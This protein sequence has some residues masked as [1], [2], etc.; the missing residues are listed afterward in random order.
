MRN[1]YLFSMIGTTAL[2]NHSRHLYPLMVMF[3]IIIFI[4]STTISANESRF[5]GSGEVI[6]WS[7]DQNINGIFEVAPEDVLIILPGVLI[8]FETPASGLLINGTIQAAGDA[9]NPIVFD[10]AGGN[11]WQGIDL[12]DACP[13]TFEYCSFQNIDRNQNKFG[14]RSNGGINISG[15]DSVSF[16]FSSF[17]GNNDGFT[18]IGSNQISFIECTF[19]NNTIAFADNGLIY[20]E[21]VFGGLVKGCTFYQNLVSTKG[22]LNI[23]DNSQLVVQQ[24]TFSNTTFSGAIFFG[25]IYPVILARAN[26]FNTQVIINGNSFL[27]NRAPNNQKLAEVQLTGKDNNIDQL[28]AMIWNNIFLGYPFPF[29]NS[30]PKG[31]IRVNSA[32]ATISH[33]SVKHYNDFGIRVLRSEAK[34]ILNT[35][36]NNNSALGALNFDSYSIYSGRSVNNVVYA[37]YFANNEAP[38]GAAIFYSGVEGDIVQMTIHDNI[39]EEN[40]A[41]NNGGA[42]NVQNISEI[43]IENN[44]FNQNTAL[45]GGAVYIKG[46]GIPSANII[47][48]S[49]SVSFTD[50]QFSANTSL[51]AGGGVFIEDAAAP[52]FTRNLFYANAGLTGAGLFISG[53]NAAI[54]NCNFFE[55]QAAAEGGGLFL[56][57]DDMNEISIQNCNFTGNGNSGGIS[58]TGN[59]LPA[60]IQIYNTLFFENNSGAAG[61]AIIFN[62]SQDVIT[63]NCYFDVFPTGYSVENIDPQQDTWPGWSGINI[64]YLDCETS[65]CVDNG[66]PD[67]IYNDLQGSD[68]GQALFPSCGTLTNDIGISG[69]PFAANKSWLFQPAEPSENISSDDQYLK[70]QQQ[71]ILEANNQKTIE[72]PNDV[73]IYP[74]PT[75]GKFFISPEL[76]IQGTFSLTLLN[77]NGL[78]VDESKLIPGPAGDLSFLDLTGFPKGIY[79]L[80]MAN[81]QITI[82]KKIILN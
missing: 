36:E 1:H 59:I 26:N 39:F 35:I 48:S 14:Q 49:G 45:K 27:N 61:N 18:I 12:I 79:I 13:S 44:T 70:S 2:K 62:S 66:N 38:N 20:F 32:V 31:A 30:T 77:S 60:N 41:D 10:G 22:M 23:N 34:V 3:F 81:Q 55:N 19:Q 73:V 16:S 47:R 46:S 40:K 17:S 75:S 24:N 42:I 53:S 6:T 11:T 43:L 74:N 21:S 58:I 15:T 9:Q 65:I 82:T 50:N 7:Q 52:S 54:Y 69:G 4:S 80:L 68:P 78:I 56:D 57:I 28:T 8:E 33:N 71:N 67:E 51:D 25:T 37:N 76:Q 5:C 64:F 63:H 72:G 29:P